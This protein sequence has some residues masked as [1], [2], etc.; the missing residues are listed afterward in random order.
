MSNKVIL[1]LLVILLIGVVSTNYLGKTDSK[2]G[3]SFSK[4]ESGSNSVTYTLAKPNVDRA[5]GVD[6]FIRDD[7]LSL[8][9]DRKFEKLDNKLET[10]AVSFEEG[11]ITEFDFGYTMDS[12]TGIEPNIEALILE[13]V[14]ST[15]SWSSY[16]ASS[17]YFVEMAWQWRGNAY[18]HLVPKENFKK[19]KEMLNRSTDFLEKAKQNNTRDVIWFSKKIELANGLNDDNEAAL[20]QEAI[21]TFPQST[22]IYRSAIFAQQQKWG[23]TKRLHQRLVHD[24]S[25]LMDKED[26]ERGATILYYEAL[27]AAN[28]KDYTTAITQVKKAIEKNPNRIDYY[29]SL[30]RYF[31]MQK[32][33]DESILTLNTVLKYWPLSRKSLQLRAQLLVK[34]GVFH[35]T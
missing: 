16:L 29:F 33:F 1:G 27:E 22:E 17:Q 3:V 25:V 18:G 20:I 21:E 9:R 5:L 10:L 28:E 11:N 6:P 2:S 13:W 12:F 19:Y 15:G 23:G 32:R 26:S 14:E 35:P 31:N 4:I 34:K 7:L 8:L 24:Y 30:A